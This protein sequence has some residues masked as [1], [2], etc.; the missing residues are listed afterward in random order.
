MEVLPDGFRN[1]AADPAA[2]HKGAS[3]PVSAAV[4]MCDQ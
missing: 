4:A 3:A 2:A 1:L